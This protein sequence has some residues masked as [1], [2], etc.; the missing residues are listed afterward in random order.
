MLTDASGNGVPDADVTISINPV[1]YYKGV[2][3]WD[4]SLWSVVDSGAGACANEDV[5]ENGILDAGEDTNGNGKLDPGNVVAAPSTVTTGSDGS[6]EFDLV[7]AEDYADW[8]AVKL[9]A[10]TEVSG[11]EAT[12]TVNFTLPVSA[13]DINVQTVAPPGPTSLYGTAA[14]CT[15]PT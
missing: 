14:V 15:D 4:G 1:A 13:A 11:T 12:H 9:T 6:F 2:R 8:V 7:Y 10:A 3:A 5:N